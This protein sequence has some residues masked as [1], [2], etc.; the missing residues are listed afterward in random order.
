MC[1]RYFCCN[2][3]SLYEVWQKSNETSNN[4]LYVKL[5]E[6]VIVKFEHAEHLSQAQ[7]FSLTEI[8]FGRQVHFEDEHRSG[9]LSSSKIDENIEHVNNLMDQIVV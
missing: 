3:N 9:E 5:G 6:S 4:K 1:L 2:S 7:V 8:I